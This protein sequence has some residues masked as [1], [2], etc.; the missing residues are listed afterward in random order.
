MNSDKEYYIELIQELFQ[1]AT[2]REVECV[3][4]FVRAYLGQAD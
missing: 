3:W 1:L 4:R 2:V